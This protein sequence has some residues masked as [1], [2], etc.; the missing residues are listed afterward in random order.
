MRAPEARN[1]SR[2]KKRCACSLSIEKRMHRLALAG[3]TA[4]MIASCD[5][6][7]IA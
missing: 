3:A 4:A 1:R 6:L 7:D 2:E 5:L